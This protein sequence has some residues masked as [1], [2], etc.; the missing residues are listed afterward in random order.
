LGGEESQVSMVN[1]N[2]DLKD[3]NQPTIAPFTGTFRWIK[4]LNLVLCILLILSL[5]VWFYKHLA[6]YFKEILFAGGSLTLL[7][8]ARMLPEILSKTGSEPD[9][10]QIQ[11]FLGKKNSI[12][13]ICAALLISG[14]LH[15]TTSSIYFSFEDAKNGE[16]EYSIEVRDAETGRLFM[17]PLQLSS[18]E[19][20]KGRPFFWPDGKKILEIS[21]RGKRYYETEICTLGFGGTVSENIPGRFRSKALGLLRIVPGHNSVN[22]LPIEWLPELPVYSM[23][24][25]ITGKDQTCTYSIDSLRQQEI[26]LGDSLNLEWGVTSLDQELLHRQ[27]LWYYNYNSKDSPLNLIKLN[28]ETLRMI[29]RFVG[30]STILP[31]DS[32]K[33]ELSLTVNG[34]NRGQHVP[35]DT[36]MDSS[37][38]LTIYPEWS[39]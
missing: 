29:R 35:V 39:Q 3:K 37:N 9:K 21:I 8:L 31:G 26:F 1:D 16:S 27:V 32:I 11:G 34:E 19:G 6:P 25:T 30:T 4:L 20:I 10:A 18:Y 14:L 24:V 7:S 33:V 38:V 28:A 13:I 23:K 2:K 15:S 12:W 36:I 22:K 5:V 17:E